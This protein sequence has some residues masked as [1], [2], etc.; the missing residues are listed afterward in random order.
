MATAV[1]EHTGAIIKS[2]SGNYEAFSKNYDLLDSGTVF[3]SNV[4]TMFPITIRIPQQVHKNLS[5]LASKSNKSVEELAQ[6][7][8]LMHM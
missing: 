5:A 6:E 1:N 3:K 7:L 4:V 8:F 2:G